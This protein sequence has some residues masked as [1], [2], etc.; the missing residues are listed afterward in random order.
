MLLSGKRVYKV[1]GAGEGMGGVGK[2]TYFML[3][4]A[5]LAFK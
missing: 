2:M 4:F 1:Q 3:M 5:P